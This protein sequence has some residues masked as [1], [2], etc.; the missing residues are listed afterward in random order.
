MKT[1]PCLT[2]F[3]HFG[4]FTAVFLSL[5][6]CADSGAQDVR[7]PQTRV[8]P[9]AASLPARNLAACSPDGEF[10]A[11]ATPEGCIKFGSTKEGARRR[12]E[13]VCEPRAMVF[14]S[15]GQ[16]LAVAGGTRN[17]IPYIKVWRMADG[18]LLCKIT[19][20]KIT[21]DHA[22]DPQLSFSADGQFL[23]STGNGALIN[24]WQ[25]PEGKLKWSMRVERPV[26]RLA[27]TKEGKAVVAVF[28][29]G[30]IQIFPTDCR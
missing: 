23:V 24:L 8:A 16:F 10:Y 11:V 14:S 22:V 25:L 17:C 15:D 29:D 1:P 6:P 13:H 20:G 19:T 12:T 3:S 2:L 30:S 27:F 26:S 7:A 21:T 28:A 18:A 4:G 9:A 5:M